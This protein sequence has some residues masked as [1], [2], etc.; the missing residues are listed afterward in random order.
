MDGLRSTRRISDVVRALTPDI[1]AFQE[2]HQRLVRSGGEDQP[3]I[4]GG[5][6]NRTFT[7][8]RLLRFGTGGYGIGLAV[9]STIIGR[10]EHLLPG[11]NE[12][13]GA[14]ELR[15][16]D[17]DGHRMTA[18]CTHWGLDADERLRQAEALA[19]I[20]NASFGP[21][22]LCG[23]FNEGI[24][25]EAVQLLLARTGLQDADADRQRATFLSI[26]PTQRIDFVLH[27]AELKAT[28]V[29]VIASTASDH[30][31]VL[32]DLEWR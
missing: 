18:I 3:S 16:R 31:P 27:S 13:R 10:T 17:V 7:F 30:L 8:Q 11:G 2:I 14:L 4:L 19:D 22:V 25:G 23:D 12:Q 6:L 26:D 21:V 9:R 1:V 32:V 20:V 28:N 24:T 5:L 29:E 15:L